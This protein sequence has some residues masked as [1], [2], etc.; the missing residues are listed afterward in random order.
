MPK[1]T[2]KERPS[3]PPAWNQFYAQAP[4]D[5]KEELNLI[6]RGFQ[7]GTFDGK[8]S[9]QWCPK[10]A[11]WRCHYVPKDKDVALDE[12]FDCPACETKLRVYVEGAWVV[13]E[14]GRRT[15]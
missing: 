11:R 14:S 5:E 7:D 9:I 2:F 3:D 15:T 1:K 6:Y 4:S 12:V 10:C 8:L 13:L